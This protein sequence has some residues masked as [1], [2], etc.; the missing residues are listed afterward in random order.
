MQ[1]HYLSFY[2]LSWWNMSISI[3]HLVEENMNFKSVHTV[4][5][6]WFHEQTTWFQKTRMHQELLTKVGM[7]CD[8]FLRTHF[9]IKKRSTRIYWDHAIINHVC[10]FQFPNSNLKQAT[11][12]LIVLSQY[13]LAW[14]TLIEKG[15]WAISG[16]GAVAFAWQQKVALSHGKYSRAF[17]SLR[18]SQNYLSVST[19]CVCTVCI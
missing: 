2:V 11:T 4:H 8:D 18:P 5:I 15:Q 16:F 12:L 7:H 13:G 3:I 1:G 19:V 6:P 14:N 9:E 10:L 17:N